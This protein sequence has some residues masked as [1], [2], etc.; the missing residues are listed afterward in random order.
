MRGVGPDAAG[1]AG[2]RG[3]GERPAVEQAGQLVAHGRAVAP[4]LPRVETPGP[5]RDGERR[6]RQQQRAARGADDAGVGA[7]GRQVGAEAAVALRPQHADRPELPGERA[8]KSAHRGVDRLGVAVAVGGE[9]LRGVVVG[10]VGQ[11]RGRV[12]GEHG[13][14]SNR[15]PQ[16]TDPGGRRFRRRRPS[17]DS[18]PTAA[19]PR[20]RPHPPPRAP[21]RPART[22]EWLYWCPVAVEPPLSRGGDGAGGGG[23]RRSDSGGWCGGRAGGCVHRAPLTGS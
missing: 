22:V 9:E 16:Q 13:S 17:S 14:S 6:G 18:D 20:P 12:G 3:R 2:E 11:E 19:R 15:M 23:R 8:G 4:A 21:P 10:D 5:G 1:Q 7:V